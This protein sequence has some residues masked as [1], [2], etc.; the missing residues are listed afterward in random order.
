[1]TSSFYVQATKTYLMEKFKVDLEELEPDYRLSFGN[2]KLKK[3]GIASFNL[4]PILH[5]PMAGECK[6][7]CYATVGQQAFKS[8]VLRRARAFKASLQEDFVEKMIAEIKK[9]KWV[10]GIRIHDSGDFYT[11]EYLQ[12]WCDIARAFPETRFYAYTKSLRIVLRAY[13]LGYIPDNLR[14]IQ[15]EGGVG[16]KMIREDLPHA[17][18]FSTLEEL[19]EA[20]YADASET[21]DEAAFGVSNK[22]GLVVHGAKKKKFVKSA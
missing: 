7:F 12:K 16:D 19:Q 1:M 13:D 11:M 22:I 3:S 18:I 14:I 21:D 15:S 20:G 9:D 17:R 8:G 6:K 2:T 5:C 10:R 4:I